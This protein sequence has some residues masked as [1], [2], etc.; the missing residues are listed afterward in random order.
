[1]GTSSRSAPLYW[2]LAIGLLAA[3]GAYAWFVSAQYGRLNDLNQRELAN[4]A[5]EL[6]RTLENAVETVTAS[7]RP[8]RP[9]PAPC[10]SSMR[11]SPT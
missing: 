2:R 1:M 4:A 3:A 10:A 9:T 5:A 6:K 11:I 7:T 8:R